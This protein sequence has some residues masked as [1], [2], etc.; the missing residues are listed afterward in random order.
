M[1]YTTDFTSNVTLTTLEY[2]NTS[3]SL[4]KPTENSVIDL[5]H[6][7][8]IPIIVFLGLMGNTVSILI[9]TL[10]YLNR[11]SSSAYLAFLA[12]VD[13]VFLFCLLIGW[14]GYLR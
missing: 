13:S 3:I 4:S 12:F 8:L 7:Y 11:Q 6:I 2:G 5:L 1:S 9:F 14:F 10:T